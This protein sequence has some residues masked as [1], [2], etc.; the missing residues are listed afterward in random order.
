VKR[1][2][3]GPI[4]CIM[5][6]PL[7]GCA[8]KTSEAPPAAAPGTRPAERAP[9]TIAPPPE[10]IKETLEDLFPIFCV[11]R[12]MPLGEKSALWQKKYGGRWIRWS[13]KIRSFTP[14][15]MTVQMRPEAL[16]FDLSLWMDADHAQFARTHYKV[17]DHVRFSAQL[18][19]YDDV[20]QKLYLSHTTILEK[21]APPARDAGW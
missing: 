13:G 17:G 10:F 14:N 1:S 8:D 16:T 3:L 19:S 20:F 9:A 18:S 15:G 11:Y 7:P 21:L 2:W 12:S 4:M 6:T 5:S